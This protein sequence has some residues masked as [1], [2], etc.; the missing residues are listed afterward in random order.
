MMRKQ[1]G[2]GLLLVLTLLVAAGG[3]ALLLV[4]P[5]VRA[6]TSLTKTVRINSELGQS[7]Q[8]LLSYSAHYPYLYGPKGAGVGHLPCPDT[9]SL[10]KNVTQWSVKDGPNPPC[11]KYSEAVGHLPRHI[12]FSKG[13]YMFHSDPLSRVDYTVSTRVVNNPQNNP[14]N[15]TLTATLREVK[16]Y[17]ALLRQNVGNTQSG[18][19]QY[20]EYPL[21]NKALMLG[22][23]PSVAAWVVDKYEEQ[24]S[25]V[26]FA[27]PIRLIDEAINDASNRCHEVYLLIRRCRD[28]AYQSAVGWG[29]SKT[30]QSTRLAL[31]LAD[32]I[33]EYFECAE[34]SLSQIFIDNVPAMQHW[35]VKNG[36]LD[37]IRIEYDPQ[38]IEYL[39]PQ[40]RPEYVNTNRQNTRVES[41]VIRWVP[42]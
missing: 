42:Q 10:G 35:L 33:P 4:S 16:A 17:A 14:V 13:R 38:C 31:S 37:W 39:Q 18:Q 23:R 1:Q 11:G 7:R 15:P 24:A 41:V 30:V 40:C 28:E 20:F 34:N 36:W 5:G 12:S 26:C 29:A 25:S 9:D 21:T 3:Y 2:F 32:D 22:V 6:N 8:A 27:F 19:P